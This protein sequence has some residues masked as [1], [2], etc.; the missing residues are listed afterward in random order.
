MS[1]PLSLDDIEGMQPVELNIQRMVFSVSL[2]KQEAA[3]IASAAKFY[4]MRA[5]DYMRQKALEAARAS[6]VK[7]RSA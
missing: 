2:S 3:E 5:I 4:E 1:E 6:H 7:W